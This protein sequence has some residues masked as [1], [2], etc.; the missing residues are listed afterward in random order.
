MRVLFLSQWYTPEP[1]FIG[2]TLV[3][4]LSHLGYEIE[5]IT[6]FPNYPDGVLYPGY[7]LKLVQREVINGISVV[8]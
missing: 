5:V 3:Q 2:P 4:G 8:R 6:G 7:K 1:T